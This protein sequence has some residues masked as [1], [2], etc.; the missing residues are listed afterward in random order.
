MN[1]DE[2][3]NLERVEADHWYYAGKREL[4]RRWLRRAGR[5]APDDVLLDCGA[6]TGRF[7]EEMSAHCRVLALDDHAESLE[8]LRRRLG[9]DRVISLGESG[10]PL[11]DASVDLVTALDVLEHIPDDAGA[12]AGMGRVLKPGGVLVATVPAGME[13]WSDWDTALHHCRRYSRDSLRE[14]FGP[15]EWTIFHLNYTNVAV[16]PAVWS[17]RRWQKRFPRRASA[18]AEDRLP[19]PWLNLALRRLFVVTGLWRLPFPRGVSLLVVA[20]RR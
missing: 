11:P 12:L 5:P 13:L 6:G 19:P 7:A 14:L 8:L 17:I 1:P 9:A 2:Y 10:I 18:R 20:I 3:A 4:V 15:G 16:W